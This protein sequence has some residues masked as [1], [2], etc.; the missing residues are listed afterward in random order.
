[1]DTQ[2]HNDLVAEVNKSQ[3]KE[4]IRVQWPSTGGPVAISKYSST[5]I[6]TQAFPWL[7]PGGIGDIKDFNG[8]VK[9]WGENMLLYENGQ[10]TSDKFFCFC[11]LNYIIRYRNT[12]TSGNWF[13]K[14]FNKGGPRNLEDFKRTFKREIS[15][16]SIDLHTSTNE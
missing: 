7:F 14:E 4:F 11:A 9:K 6:I 2:I 1:M 10:F 12:T 5:R 3:R 15:V 8:D 13:I 16:L